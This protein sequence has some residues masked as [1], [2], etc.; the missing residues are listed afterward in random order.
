[1]SAAPP[2]PG[3]L[4]PATPKAFYVDFG[5]FKWFRVEDVKGGRFVGGF[6]RVASVRGRCEQSNAAGLG[7]RACPTIARPPQPPHLLDHPLAPRPQPQPPYP[8]SHPPTPPPPPTPQIQVSDYLAAKPDP[9]AAFAGPVCGHMNADHQAD[10]LAMVK[11]Y[12]GLPAVT[13]TMLDLDRLGTN[14]RVT[15]EEGGP[16]MKVRLPFVRCARGQAGGGGVGW[17]AARGVQEAAGE[18]AAAGGAGIRRPRA[19]GSAAA[20]PR[21]GAAG[22]GARA[23][24]SR[25]ER[26]HLAQPCT[27][28]RP[29]APRALNIPPQARRGPQGREGRHRGDDARRA[30]RRGVRRPPPRGT[31]APLALSPPPAAACP[32]ALRA[33]RR[34]LRGRNARPRTLAGTRRGGGLAGGP[35]TP[36]R[37]P[38]QKRAV[39][40]A[41][42]AA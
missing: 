13:A 33:R 15:T 26:Q 29:P 9:V 16:S 1:L 22:S 12:T 23:A 37:G 34:P 5:D 10:I 40:A 42:G 7:R 3:P 17:G 32:R 41:R 24:A 28:A 14:L 21:R 25:R 39:H 31:N 18:A 19:V 27:P 36:L 20:K 2:D 30:R 11:H 4:P 38:M 35:G 8:H 6:G